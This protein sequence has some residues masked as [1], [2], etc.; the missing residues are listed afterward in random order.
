MF[1]RTRPKVVKLRS[2]PYTKGVYAKSFVYKRGLKFGELYSSNEIKQKSHLVSPKD[3]KIKG[4]APQP[5]P[6]LP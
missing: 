5:P 6:P 1:G 3:V 2:Y 4:Q